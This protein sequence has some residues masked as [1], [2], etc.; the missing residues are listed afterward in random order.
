MKHGRRWKGWAK[1]TL[2]LVVLTL[3]ACRPAPGARQNLADDFATA[4]HSEIVQ[5]SGRLGRPGFRAYLGPALRHDLDGEWAVGRQDARGPAF[6]F[7]LYGAQPLTLT[8]AARDKAAKTVRFLCNGQP[9]GEAVFQP[10]Q[11]APIKVPLEAVRPGWNWIEVEGAAGVAFLEAFLRPAGSALSTVNHRPFSPRLEADGATVLLPFGERLS[12]PLEGWKGAR[13]RLRVEPWVEAGAPAPEPSALRLTCRRWTDGGEPWEGQVEGDAER[14]LT[15]PEGQ[16]RFALTFQAGLEGEAPRPGQAGVRLSAILE[17]D[18]LT[19][20]PSPTSPS[21]TSTPTPTGSPPIAAV[22][23]RAPSLVLIVIDTL[24][25]DRLS[26]YG[27][28]HPTS[29]HLQALARDGVVFDKVTAQAPWTKPT[30]ASLITGLEPSQHRAKDFGDHLDGSLVTLAETLKGAGYQ[31][32]AAVANPLVSAGYGFDQGF[33]RFESLPV[34]QTAPQVHQ[35]GLDLLKGRDKGRPF[36]LYL[37]PIDPHLPYDPPQPWRARAL[38]WH[39]LKEGEGLLPKRFPKSSRQGF[40]TLSGDLFARFRQGQPADLP[41]LT[42]KA[43]KALY[44]GEVA[45]SDAA[46]GLVVERLRKEGLYDQTMIVVTSDHGEEL[47]ERGRLGHMHTLYEELLHVPLVVKFPHSAG[48][49]RRVAQPYQQIDLM[50]TLLKAVGLGQAAESDG[51]PYPD[52]LESRVGHFEVAAGRDATAA[53]QAVSDYWEL[54]RGVVDG[55]RKLFHHDSSV[56]ADRQP[57]AL[58]DLAADPGERENLILSQPLE[59]LFLERELAR[60]AS[61]S[62]RIRPRRADADQTRDVLRSLQYMR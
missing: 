55:S 56:C 25:A 29:P 47:L 32:W 2:T 58:F 39:G 9:L 19:A 41:P 3:L 8:V 27:H 44:D 40:N 49:G 45:T 38:A 35:A 57:R 60:R 13:L 33:D 53:G 16:E 18:R 24:R 36:F 23:A 20:S 52:L 7:F 17:G 1:A 5:G 14:V 59:A 51:V 46:V 62:S 61:R 21:P 37:H 4:R 34:T 54:G 22:P 11:E 26:V 50:P 42:E 28:P 15:L 31:T 30:V 12:F 6:G 10:A 48:A 43:V